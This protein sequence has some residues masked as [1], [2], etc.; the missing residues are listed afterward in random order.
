MSNR[1]LVASVDGMVAQLVN[2]IS[3]GYRYYFVGTVTEIGARLMR[4]QRMLSYYEAQ[5]PKWTRER[6]KKRGLANFRYL[7]YEEWFIVLAT[8]GQAPKFWN[9]DRQRIRDVRNAP[10]RFKGYS[11][12][13]RQG[14]WKDRRKW[15]D[16][17][18]REPDMKWHVRVQL[19]GETFNGVKAY[20]LNIATHR[21]ADF[22]AREFAELSFQPYRPVR[23]QLFQVLRAVNRARCQAGYQRVPASVIRF[24]RRIVR[25]FAASGIQP[26][27]V[28]H[29]LTDDSYPT[30]CASTAF[31]KHQ[32]LC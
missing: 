26:G 12:S 30:P 3:K 29:H 8:D 4:D 25:I 23:E 14:G 28:S 15:S 1:H 31:E 9:E 11:I 17:A 16:P 13:Y 19:D 6:R 32:V 21:Q 7:R 5:L 22:L 24:Q 18:V 27:I 10:I 2:L 20:F